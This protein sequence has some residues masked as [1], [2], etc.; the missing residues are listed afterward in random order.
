[1]I[2]DTVLDA[3]LAEPTIGKVHPHPG[4]I[5]DPLPI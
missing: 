3:E 4:K 2:G 5:D 1:M